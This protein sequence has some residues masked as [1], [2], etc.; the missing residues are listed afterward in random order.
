MSRRKLIV[1]NWKM[2]GL[3]GQL[4][5]ITDIDR[6]A[7]A[8]P[9]V[10]TGIC[11]PATMI[12]PASQAVSSIFIGA[13]DCHLSVSGAHTGCLSAEMLKEAGART[14]I[15]GHSERRTDQH[16]S[17]EDVAA[18]A[19][20]AHGQGLNVILCVGE[21]EAQR[22]AGD[23]ERVVAD[24]LLASLPENAAA[25]WLSI[26]YEPVWAIGTGRTPTLDEVAAMHAALRDALRS[27]IGGEA[28]AMRILYGGSMN[29]ANAASLLAVADVDGGLVGGA[30]L[31]AEKFAP[32][33]K[34]AA[35]AC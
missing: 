24:Q 26:A 18:K 16:E 22:D 34:A 10:E 6:I 8:Y 15:A 21:T 3:L 33:I 1:G 2:N 5:E 31:T 29:G 20:A 12:Y 7:A 27:R 23:A 32:I 11:P 17:H 4:K 14:I 9:A 13:Q 30:S 19:S 25:E 35:A 28:D